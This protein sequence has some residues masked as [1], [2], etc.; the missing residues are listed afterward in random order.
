MIKRLP[1]VSLFLSAALAAC[2]SS[3]S[4]RFRDPT[5][6]EWEAADFGED[7]GN[8]DAAI[9]A[10]MQS[11]L[12]DP[13]STTINFKDGPT[14]TWVGTAPDFRYGYGVCVDVVTRGVYATANFGST[15]FLFHDG[16]VAVVRD[17]SDGERICARLGRTPEGAREA[18]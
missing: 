1:L 5:L 6:A 7:P 11:L 13:R 16:R 12:Q 18:K 3:P 4:D 14:K 15:F 10:Y 9:R 2:A 17:G 8:Y